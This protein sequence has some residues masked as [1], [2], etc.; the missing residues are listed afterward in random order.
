M[1][2]RTEIWFCLMKIELTSWRGSIIWRSWFNGLIISSDPSK[3]SGQSSPI[4]DGWTHLPPSHDLKSLKQTEKSLQSDDHGLGQ[5]TFFSDFS[6]STTYPLT[7]WLGSCRIFKR[8][9]FIWHQNL[10]I[11]VRESIYSSWKRLWEWTWL[12]CNHWV[13]ALLYF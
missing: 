8:H 2:K 13:C 9:F 1:K 11:I 12:F 3:Q 5:Q 10:R 4:Q 6:Q 7:R